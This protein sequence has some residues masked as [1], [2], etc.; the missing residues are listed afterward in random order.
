[1]YIVPQWG[2][3]CHLYNNNNFDNNNK[4]IKDNNWIMIKLTVS[5]HFWVATKDTTAITFVSKRLSFSNRK[6]TQVHSSN[7]E[8]YRAAQRE[9]IRKNIFSTLVI[10]KI[11]RKSPF[12]IK[13]GF[14]NSQMFFVPHTRRI[15]NISILLILIFCSAWKASFTPR[16]VR[17]S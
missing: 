13:I 6:K 15:S 4:N 16:K 5:A 17:C 10:H 9:K 8:L 2:S 11:T 3:E 12:S 7:G 14:P 1:M